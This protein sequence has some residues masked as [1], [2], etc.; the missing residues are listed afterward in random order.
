MLDLINDEQYDYVIVPV[1]NIRINNYHNVKKL[2]DSL[3]VKNKV[4]VDSF[5]EIKELNN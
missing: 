1:R 4:L 2:I 3:N 5:G